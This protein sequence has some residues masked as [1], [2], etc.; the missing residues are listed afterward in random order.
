MNPFSPGS[1]RNVSYDTDAHKTDRRRSSKRARASPCHPG[2]RQ[3]VAQPSARGAAVAA[4][5]GQRWRGAR[6]RAWL[7]WHGTRYRARWKAEREKEDVRLRK[8]QQAGKRSSDHGT[9]ARA[10]G[11]LQ[12]LGAAGAIPVRRV[13][14]RRGHSP[15]PPLSPAWD[16]KV[17]ISL[18]LVPERPAHF[19]MVLCYCHSVSSSVSYM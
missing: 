7:I 12:A 1:Q 19:I 8:G 16:H 5:H 2:Q 18:E 17:L 9:G 14:E 4:A 15:P 6:A 10:G 11:R 13:P 3:Q